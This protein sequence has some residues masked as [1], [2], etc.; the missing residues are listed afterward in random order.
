MNFIDGLI[1]VV[2]IY[3]TFSGFRKGAVGIFLDVMSWVLG[4]LLAAHYSPKFSPWLALHFPKSAHFAPILGF[5]I[6]WFGAFCIFTL[7]GIVIDKMLRGSLISPFDRVIGAG[8]GFLKGL[9]VLSILLLP[10]VGS[11]L[12]VYQKAKLTFLVKP[13]ITKI[14]SKF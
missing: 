10:F 9:L 1:G 6:I 4:L 3:T 11:H 12:A 14:M 2:L 7:L 5:L 13:V 8:I